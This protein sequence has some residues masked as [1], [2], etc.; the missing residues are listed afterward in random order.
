MA[1]GA[2]ARTGEREGLPVEHADDGAVALQ[3]EALPQEEHLLVEDKLHDQAAEQRRAVLC[4]DG[5][6]GGGLLL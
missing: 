2:A 6:R 3:A 5:P 1:E 4:A